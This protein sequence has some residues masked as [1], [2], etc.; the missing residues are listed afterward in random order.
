M[1][2]EDMWPE[3]RRLRKVWW[4]SFA[5]M[6]INLRNDRQLSYQRN[7]R[8]RKTLCGIVSS[9]GSWLLILGMLGLDFKFDVTNSLNYDTCIHNTS[10]PVSWK[11][12]TAQLQRPVFWWRAESWIAVYCGD[13]N[14]CCW[15]NSELLG[16]F[17]KLQK[18]TISFV[19][20]ASLFV[21]P[22]ACII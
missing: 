21:C 8:L 5:N 13:K 7:T 3:L 15:Q 10:L 18:A 17:A 22:S 20:C 19:L 1:Q 12:D 4:L 9:N 2:F 11:T 6:M 16:A 14:A